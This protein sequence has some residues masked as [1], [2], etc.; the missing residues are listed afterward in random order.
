VIDQKVHE[1]LIAHAV[2]D[3]H[4]FAFSKCACCDSLRG[5]AEE[6]HHLEIRDAFEESFAIVK[7]DCPAVK[8]TDDVFQS[9]KKAY[10]KGFELWKS[11]LRPDNKR[12]LEAV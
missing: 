7:E 3:A 8:P 6:P 4:V 2:D 9:Y 5:E 1:E 11:L 12:R 10:L